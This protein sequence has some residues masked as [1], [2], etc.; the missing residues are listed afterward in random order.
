MK[1]KSKE[2]M[3]SLISV[4]I[5]DGERTKIELMTKGTL[6]HS[7]STYTISYDDTEAT[8]YEGSTTTIKVCGDVIYITRQGTANTAI[9]FE[10]GKKYFAH[11][12]TPFGC[13]QIGVY[14]QNVVNTIKENG[15]LYIKYALD[16]NSSPL[17]ENEIIVK[18]N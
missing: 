11:Y 8:G 10:V 5:Q 15:Q 17:S 12:E 1:N 7:N 9:S 2:V 4:Q 16:F 14:G 18:I 6:S 13:M 3:I